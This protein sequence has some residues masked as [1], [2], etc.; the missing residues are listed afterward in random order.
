MT[1][2]ISVKEAIVN[3]AKNFDVIGATES[4]A[5]VEYYLATQPGLAESFRTVLG[6]IHGYDYLI[7]DC[8]PSLG[9]LNQNVLAFC[10]EIFVPVSADFL[11]Y[12]ALRK[13]PGIVKEINKHFAHEIKMTKVIPTLFDKRNKI[14]KEMLK[15]MHRDFPGIVSAPIRLNSKVKEAPKHG[16]SIFSYAKNSAGAKDYGLLVEDIL[17]A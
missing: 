6:N 13:V 7:V 10:D 3:I 14:C 11:G 4:L 5:K 1:G 8:P 2:K 9:V 16:K 12:D 15:M 17:S